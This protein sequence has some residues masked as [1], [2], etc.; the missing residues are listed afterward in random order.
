MMY[1]FGGGGTLK[2]ANSVNP[3]DFYFL[4]HR[5]ELFVWNHFVQTR[6]KNPDENVFIIGEIELG[7]GQ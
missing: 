7:L 2:T 1:N 5:L 6:K 4:M 3:V